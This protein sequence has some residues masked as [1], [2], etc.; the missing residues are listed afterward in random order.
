MKMQRRLQLASIA[1]LVGGGVLV[2]LTFNRGFLIPVVIAWTSLFAIGQFW[3]FRCPNC[4]KLASAR[5][6]KGEKAWAEDQCRYC[7]AA[8]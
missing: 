8:Y 5:S 1:F 4:G 7:G 2:A 6:K 3:L